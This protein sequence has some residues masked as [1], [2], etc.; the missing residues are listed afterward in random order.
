MNADSISDQLNID[1]LCAGTDVLLV[2][3]PSNMK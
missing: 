2:D 3:T 1:T